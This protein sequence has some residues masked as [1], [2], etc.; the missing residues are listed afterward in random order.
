MIKNWDFNWQ[1]DYR[2]A[3]PATGCLQWFLTVRVIHC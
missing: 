2:Y 1:G 3:E